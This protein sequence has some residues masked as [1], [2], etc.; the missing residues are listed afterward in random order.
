MII[1]GEITYMFFPAAPQRFRK[2][3]DFATPG[4]EEYSKEKR[5]S[6]PVSAEA[7]MTSTKPS[8]KGL[9]QEW[10]YENPAPCGIVV[11]VDGSAESMAAFNTAATLARTRKCAMHVVS[12]IPVFPDYRIDPQHEGARNVEELR[13]QLRESSIRDM[14]H[15]VGGEKEKWTYQV[16]IGRPAE[17]LARIADERRA[18]LVILGRRDH[19]VLDR[20]VSGETSLQVMRLSSVP[21][22]AVPSD[23][24]R[25]DNIVVASDFSPA[26]ERAAKIAVELARKSGAVYLV[27][28]EPPADF[29]P[30]GFTL[31]DEPQSSE[32]VSVRFR[33]LIKALDVPEGMRVE[34]V[35]LNGKPVRAVLEF[36]YRV[37]AD[38]IAAGSHGHTRL[39]RLILCSVSS[40]LVRN[41]ACS[42]L[43]V[44]PAT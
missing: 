5:K 8:I 20:L 34:S 12:V 16:I 22:L 23:L 31:P 30:G 2:R 42:V 35:V 4:K 44:P 1:C 17:A 40:G 18:D 11:G 15:A 39:Q 10:E 36:A 25:A 9:F 37:G 29:L 43:V 19:G 13:V 14:F 6:L 41:A 27:Y 38:M 26:S 24:E 3:A 32:G 7:A 21:V 28:V 33:R